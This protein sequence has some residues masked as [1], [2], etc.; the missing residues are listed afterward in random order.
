MRIMIEAIRRKREDDARDQTGGGNAGQIARQEKEAEAAQD[1][2]RE[3]VQIVDE[4][5]R[6]AQPDKW[7]TDD[8]LQQYRIGIRQC[9]FRRIK[10]VSVKQV[11]RVTPE[12]VRDPRQPPHG[13]VRVVVSRHF[14]RMSDLRPSQRAGQN[15]EDQCRLPARD[16]HRAYGGTRYFPML[17]VLT[18]GLMR[19]G[20]DAV[21]AG[22]TVSILGLTA[23]GV[24]V[25]VFL[26]RLGV[27]PSLVM[28]ATALSIAPY[29]V[30]DTA[31]AIRCEPM[32]AAFA[33]FGLAAITPIETRATSASNVL[34][35]AA[36]FV[37]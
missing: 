19:L 25:A 26:K 33:I 10:N 31:F 3:D 11:K 29:F 7:G 14:E 2:R 28:A 5:N 35:A 20:L 18:A 32:A 16:P 36:L 13:E 30:H 23:M 8:P 34:L 27:P 12:L 9:V 4:H 21:P 22:V 17:F 15:D 1:E 24:A 37:A 6:C